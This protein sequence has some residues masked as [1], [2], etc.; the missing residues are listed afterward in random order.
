MI[1]AV[2]AR[3]LHVCTYACSMLK[4]I[5]LEVRAL[6]ECASRVV[7]GKG[8]VE[9]AAVSSSPRSSYRRRKNGYATSLG[10][11]SNQ[12]RQQRLTGFK[13]TVPEGFRLQIG[14]F[15]LFWRWIIFQN[16]DY[17]WPWGTAL[18]TYTK[19]HS[20]KR[21]LTLHIGRRP[22]APAAAVRSKSE[23]QK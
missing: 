13:S 8:K 7:L 4:C 3:R 23:V 18:C 22:P 6:I 17:L 1:S 15:W 10:I 5:S 12:P 20:P 16:C 19:S 21:H 11:G 14:E 9:T 2:W